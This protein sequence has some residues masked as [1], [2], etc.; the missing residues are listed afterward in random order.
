MTAQRIMSQHNMGRGRQS[1]QERQTLVVDVC[2]P[3]SILESCRL[4]VGLQL[5]SGK[6]TVKADA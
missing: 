5:F 6:P 1:K 3:S 2:G 4:E